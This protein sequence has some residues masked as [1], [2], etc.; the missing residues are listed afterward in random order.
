MSQT[1]RFGF[2]KFG[3]ALGGSISDDGGKFSSTDRDTQDQLLAFFENHQHDGGDSPVALASPSLAPTAVIHDIGGTITRGG[4]RYYKFSVIDQF[5][6]ESSASPEAIVTLPA[7]ISVTV[8]PIILGDNGGGS[9]LAQGS[10]YYALTG[11]TADGE[12]VLGP[13]GIITIQV[14]QNQADLTLPALP[15]GVT[16]WN[17]W[18]MGV[19][20][21]GWS[22]VGDSQPAGLFLD[23]GFPS[24][25]C[26]SDP[27]TQ[28]PTLDLA[29]AGT[30]SVT[31]TPDPTD[32]VGAAS[33]RLYE[34]DTSGVYGNASL[35]VAVVPTVVDDP[36]PGDYLDTGSAL[37]TGQPLL[38]STTIKPSHSVVGGGGGGGGGGGADSHLITTMVPVDVPA[39]SL[40]SNIHA[41]CN[42]AFGSNGY[43]LTLLPDLAGDGDE[44]QIN[45]DGVYTAF[46]QAHVEGIAPG[47][48]LRVLLALTAANGDA[49]QLIPMI[50]LPAPCPPGE[51]TADVAFVTPPVWMGPGTRLAG[52]VTV[53][54]AGSAP[55]VLTAS[56]GVAM[57]SG[58]PVVAEV[59]PQPGSGMTITPTGGGDVSIG[60]TTDPD[61]EVYALVVYRDDTRDVFFTAN[62]ATNPVA[63]TGL[64]EVALYDVVLV[65]QKN[66]TSVDGGVELWSS[67]AFYAQFAYGSMLVDEIFSGADVTADLGLPPMAVSIDGVAT[68]TDDLTVVAGGGGP[69]GPLG[70]STV[71]SDA[72]ADAP[73][74]H[75]DENPSDTV[76]FDNTGYT[77]ADGS[78]WDDVE[79]TGDNHNTAWVK[80]EC[81]KTGTTTFT[82]TGPTA[83]QG[84]V[85]IYDDAGSLINWDTA[86]ISTGCT[87]GNTYWL[88]LSN[89]AG[90]ASAAYAFTWSVPVA[91]VPTD[92]L[93]DAP[94]LDTLTGSITFDNRA[95][96]AADANADSEPYRRTGW[97]VYNCLVSG[98][99]TVDVIG[100]G[101]DAMVNVF[102]GLTPATWVEGLIING[103]GSHPEVDAGGITF[104]HAVVAGTSYRIVV[105]TYQDAGSAT[106]PT[107]PD[108][109]AHTVFSWSVPG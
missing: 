31:L 41:V 5:G 46:V 106:D 8:A 100:S 93:A 102:S 67:P 107:H 4:V 92:A 84:Y 75:N 71:P 7:A 69:G 66:V 77:A 35:V 9:T 82:I 13:E 25:S 34:S 29:P 6:F 96:T 81:T 83:G 26:L 18:R 19:S 65:A 56:F 101:Y 14:G 49:V 78:P 43:D 60:W 63:V 28:P 37:L 105:A 94:A 48:F 23:T 98:T 58:T 21:Y 55:T 50:S 86:S 22:K 99:M 72:R 44:I 15:D 40:S 76:T 51:T 103:E 27:T 53:W 36:P 62:P 87:A 57:A 2:D 1:T 16:S 91:L 74:I 59:Y 73:Y 68:V 30:I 109:G 3:G 89:T 79:V 32:L 97:L 61:D 12:T 47:D 10:Y 85:E 70:G 33:W 88:R 52:T 95:F 45:T 38:I 42:G 39:S 54:Y 90:N 24:G 20:E 104:S 80:Y 17:V 108:A 64:D 11:N